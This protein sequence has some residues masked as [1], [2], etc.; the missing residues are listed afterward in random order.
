MIWVARLKN[1]ESGVIEVEMQTFVGETVL[2]NVVIVDF[3]VSV[4]ME[5]TAIGATVLLRGGSA[6]KKDPYGM[7]TTVPVAMVLRALRVR[8]VHIR[9]WIIQYP[10]DIESDIV[11][12]F[13]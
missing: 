8:L 4:L 2:R 1:N 11:F 3:P 12:R 10:N 9:Y 7:C 5:T 13:S 6:G